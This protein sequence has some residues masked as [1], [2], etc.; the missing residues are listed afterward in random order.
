VRLVI[1][2]GGTAG[3]I[4]PALAVARRFAPGE[5]VGWIGARGGMEAAVVV[6]EDLPFWPVRAGGINRQRLG[7]QLRGAWAALL[8]LGQALALLRRLAPDAV[9][10]TGGY[11]SGPVGAAAAL[12]GIPLITL[13]ENAAPGLT[14]RLLCRVAQ[15]VAVAWEGSVAAFPPGVRR[16]VVVTGVPVRPEVLAASRSQARADLGVAEEESVVLLFGGSQGAAAL[17][18]LALTL[19]RAPWRR[20]RL[21]WVAGARYHP[22]MAQALGT[23]AEGVA[24]VAYAHHMPQLLAAA[25]VAVCRAGAATLAELAARGLPSLL[26]PSPNVSEDQQTRNAR[27]MEA[28]GAA[29][30]LPE[31]RL[32]EAPERLRELLDQPERR[33]AMGRAARSLARPQAAAELEAL[34]R[35]AAGR[36]RR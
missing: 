21:I 10:A 34:I 36:R 8:G 35:E 4:Y 11:V 3:H 20:F 18:R 17:N 9:L 15:R 33:T 24:L 6:R 27:L 7:R 31:A 12:E 29:I 5:V 19:A 16:K 25:D 13:E 32:A 1:T 2:G 23:G 26:I 30:C 22:A 14:N 28:A